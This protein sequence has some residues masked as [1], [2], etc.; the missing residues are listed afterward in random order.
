MIQTHFAL[1]ADHIREVVAKWTTEK[2]ITPTLAT[3]FQDSVRAS[4]FFTDSDSCKVAVACHDDDD[5][6]CHVPLPGCCFP[7]DEVG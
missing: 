2:D 1:R 4:P 3:M 7:A 6:F 5:A